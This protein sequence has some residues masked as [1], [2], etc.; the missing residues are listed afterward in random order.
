MGETPFQAA[1]FCRVRHAHQNGLNHLNFGELVR[2]AHPTS[3]V[4]FQAA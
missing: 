2:T 3:V 1:L 4:Y